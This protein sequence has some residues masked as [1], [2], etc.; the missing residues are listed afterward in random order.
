VNTMTAEALKEFDVERLRQ[1]FPI[2]HQQV[3]G[4]PLVYL[5]NAATTQKPEVV[6]DAIADYYRFDNANVHRGAHSLSDRATAKFESARSTLAEFLGAGS[7]AEI[8]WTR[9]TTESINLVAQCWARQNLR[10]GDKILV[11]TLEHHSNIV[12]WQMAAQECGAEVLPIPLLDSL[13]ID[14]AAL[15]NMLDE[16]VKLVSVAHVSNATGIVNPLASI[17]EK[18]KRNNSV[19]MVDGAQGIAHYGVDVSELG[20]DFYAISGHKMFGPTGIGVLWGKRELLESMSPYQGGGEMI[21]QVSFS[22][23]TYNTLP[24]KYE[25]G[26]PDIAGAIGLAAAVNYLQSQNREQLLA[27]ESDLIAYCLE[28]VSSINGISRLGNSA[29]MASVFS[30]LVE[31]VH[32]A[33]LGMLLDQEGVAIRTGHHCTQPLMHSL[34]IPGSARASFS[35]Y[36]TRAEVER[37]VQA[38]EKSLSFLR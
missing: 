24:Y 30:F 6:I 23:T 17:I 36:N 32:P 21:E 27:H 18:A 3:N 20:A 14:L 5:D 25:A 22:G 19:V 2:L 33:D 7:S 26:T 1:D 16:R 35:I 29:D 11:S 37:F 38:L 4:H 9:G 34:N 15:D 13:E 28:C 31:G 10:S 12:P 8:L